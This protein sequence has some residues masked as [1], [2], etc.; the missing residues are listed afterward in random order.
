ME[1]S[2]C[3]S[4]LQEGNENKQTNK[5]GKTKI[6]TGGKKPKIKWQTYIAL[7]YQ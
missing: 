6:K 2:I 4:N 5:P 7:I 3:S 1:I